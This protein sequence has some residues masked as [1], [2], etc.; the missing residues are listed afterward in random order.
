MNDDMKLIPIPGVPTDDLKRMTRQQRYKLRRY[1]EGLC[2]SCGRV[3]RCQ[4]SR[5]L[6]QNC[7]SIQRER[8]RQK[9]GATRRNHRAAS[10]AAA[11]AQ[12]VVETTDAT[13]SATAK[14][15]R[16]AKAKAGA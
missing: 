9:I 11:S 8:M 13:K 12:P 7:L 10:Y 3:Q 5:T 15:D 6:C 1:A 4:G 14:T 16:K 2:V